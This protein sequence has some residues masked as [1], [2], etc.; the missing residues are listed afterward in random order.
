VQPS[1]SEGFGLSVVEAMSQGIP[2]VV[3]PAG[4]LKE[5]IKDKETGI[6]SADM[7]PENIAIAITKLLNNSKLADRLGK[8]GKEFVVS[9]FN[10][11]NWVNRTISAYK[12]S[13]R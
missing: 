9:S 3:T 4:S 8:N 11:K 13:I 6:I 5:I 7:W 12:G 2:V 1:L 10:L